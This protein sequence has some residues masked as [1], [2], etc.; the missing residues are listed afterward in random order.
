MYKY[1]KIYHFINLLVTL[2]RDPETNGAKTNTKIK[3]KLTENLLRLVFI[4]SKL[5]Y[6]S[7]E[8]LIKKEEAQ[9]FIFFEK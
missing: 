8:K 9:E 7:T 6:K 5:I 2:V 4:G 1:A 3:L